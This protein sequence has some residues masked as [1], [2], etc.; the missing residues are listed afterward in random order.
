MSTHASELSVDDCVKYRHVPFPKNV[1]Y[2]KWQLLRNAILLDCDIIIEVYK[3]VDASP[4]FHIAGSDAV[5]KSNALYLKKE[6]TD[7]LDGEMSTY[8]Q[9]SKIWKW[10]N[11]FIKYDFYFTPDNKSHFNF[12]NAKRVYDFLQ[13]A[14][15]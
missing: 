8:V 15:Q 3:D 7:F 10:V 5:H 11:I 4:E 2:E 1:S 6:L 13:L 12:P 14:G 9:P